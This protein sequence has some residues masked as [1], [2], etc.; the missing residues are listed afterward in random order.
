MVIFCVFM[1][2]AR[3]GGLQWGAVFFMGFPGDEPSWMSP[4]SAAVCGRRP[5]HQAA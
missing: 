3:P 4:D 5:G 2:A 1:R